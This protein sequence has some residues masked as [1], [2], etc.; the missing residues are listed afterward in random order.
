MEPSQNEQVPEEQSVQNGSADE[1]DTYRSSTEP[2]EPE[3]YNEA[4]TEDYQADE[5]YTEETKDTYTTDEYDNETKEDGAEQTNSYQNYGEV[6]NNEE[7]QPDHLDSEQDS[8]CAS[9]ASK[10]GSTTLLQLWHLV[11]LF[12]PIYD[13]VYECRFS[14]STA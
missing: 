7:K 10:R 4:A 9:S 2:K 5:A 14:H 12:D 11:S 6:N 3:S 1:P 13:T 8:K